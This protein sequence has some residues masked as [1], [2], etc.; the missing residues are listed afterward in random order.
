MTRRGHSTYVHWGAARLQALAALALGAATLALAGVAVLTEYPRGLILLACVALALFATLFGLVHRG[1]VRVL[2]L[3]LAVALAGASVG[4]LI[5]RGDLLAVLLAVSLLLALAAA[6]GAFHAR[7]A[8]PLAPRPQRP[9]LF[10]NPRSGGGKAERFALAAEARA[11]GIEPHELAPGKDLQELVCDAVSHGADALAMAGGD[12]CQAIVAA[13]AAEHSLPYACVPA[14]TRNHFALDLGV[15]RD[16]VVG[17][18]DALVDGAERIVDLADVNGRLFVN[19]VSLGIYGEAV[20]RSTYRN[21][22][23]RTLLATLPDAVAPGKQGEPLR[24]TDPEGKQFE[25]QEGHVQILV[26]NNRYRL[27]KLAGSRMRPEMDGGLLGVIV[28][29]ERPRTRAGHPLPRGQG[30]EWTARSFTVEAGEPIAA[31]IDGEAAQLEPPLHFG[32]RPRALKVRISR[33]HPGASQSAIAPAGA[34]DGLRALVSIAVGRVP[35]ASSQAYVTP[36]TST[37]PG[38]SSRPPGGDLTG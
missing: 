2:G 27:G 12:G 26:S 8:L 29:G 34:W 31:G 22:K 17:A 13:V 23:L 7:V 28:V 33:T 21:A 1:V 38:S 24:W 3:V 32:T 11:R 16:D 20:Q 5:G 9:V 19:N 36:P 35:K 6:S 30:R 10:Y 37:R 15:D 4:L 18:L 14:G 25:G